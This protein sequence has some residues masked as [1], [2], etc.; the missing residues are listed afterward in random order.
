MI[1][2]NQERGGGGGERMKK[3]KKKK[4]KQRKEIEWELNHQ[5]STWKHYP[6][7]STTIIQALFVWKF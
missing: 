1:E 3:K 4:K 7:P 5:P 6:L 2:G